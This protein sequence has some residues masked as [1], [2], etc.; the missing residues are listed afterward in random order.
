MVKWLFF[1]WFILLWY[2][3]LKINKTCTVSHKKFYKSCQHILH[4]LVITEHL[5]LNT[6]YYK[7]QNKMHIKEFLR[8]YTDISQIIQVMS[9]LCSTW[10]VGNLIFRVSFY[11]LVN[12]KVVENRN[13]TRVLHC[14]IYFVGSCEC[15]SKQQR[16]C[17]A[18]LLIW[19][20]AYFLRFVS[21][22]GFIRA[23]CILYFGICY[24]SS[25]IKKSI[26][27]CFCFPVWCC[28]CVWQLLTATIK[29]NTIKM[30]YTK[31]HNVNSMDKTLRTNTNLKK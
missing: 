10:N 30:V 22:G 18:S 16:I 28:S 3:I 20:D 29:Y 19:F 5:V 4:V 14:Q 6:W 11:R 25:V 8:L 9:V 17:C 15:F 1:L 21:V 31:I 12:V 7:T 2:I 23:I 27:Y 24:F 26:Y 13:A